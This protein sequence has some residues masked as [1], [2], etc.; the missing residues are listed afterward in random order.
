M[1]KKLNRTGGFTLVEL[2]VVIAVLG[3]LAGI[4]IPRLTGVTDQAKYS[5]GET[6]LAN[7]RTMIEI[8]RT[9]RGASNMRDLEDIVDEYGDGDTT[10]GGIFSEGWTISSDTDT[11]ISTDDSI[12][13][14]NDDTDDDMELDVDTGD[15]ERVDP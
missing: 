11:E 10:P 13:I 5:A 9:Q 14:T 15:I 1:F 2:I 4:A 3:I 8:E 6:G 12:T 7:L